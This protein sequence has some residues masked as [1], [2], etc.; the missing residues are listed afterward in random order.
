MVDVSAAELVSAWER[1]LGRAPVDQAL[2]L[3]SLASPGCSPEAMAR[4]S[5]GERDSRLLTL[6][7]QLFGSQLTSV[8]RCPACGQRLELA[9]EVDNLRRPAAA[10]PPGPDGAF[11]LSVDGYRVQ[12]RLP[13]STDLASASALA[14]QESARQLVLE[15]CIQSVAAPGDDVSATGLGSRRLPVTVTEAIVARMN[16]AD[17]QSDTKLD[18]S[19][20][21]CR[22]RWVAVFD[23][24]AYLMR[25]VHDRVVQLLRE[26]HTLAT[27][28]GWHESDI[29]AMTTTRRRAYL[30]LVTRE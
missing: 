11:E 1:A 26:V 10:L 29:L 19:C 14:D 22:H 9:F 5:V 18:V 21:D 27:A 6:R 13:N 16:E 30:Q 8:T 7:E 24:A 28:Y 20:P 2:V 17:P 23:I 25:E 3:L 12:F 4:L 15:R